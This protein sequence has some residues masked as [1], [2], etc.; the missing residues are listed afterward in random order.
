MIQ[1]NTAKPYRVFAESLEQGAIDQFES[2]MQCPFTVEGALMPD[3]HMGYSLPIGAVVVTKGVIVPAWVGFDIG[4]GVCALPV[5]LSADKVRS[6]AKEIYDLIRLSVPVGFAHNKED[7][8]WDH[9]EEIQA[10]PKLREIFDKNGLKQLG[11]L[12]GG[13][14]FIEVGVDLSEQVWVV[15]HSGS[16]GIGHA[17]ATHHMK[18]ASG[19]GKAREG[20]YGLEHST[21]E[22]GD[23]WIDQGFCLDFARENRRQIVKRVFDVLVKVC[24]EPGSPYD[25]R[26]MINRNHNHVEPMGDWWIHRKGATHAEEGMTGVIPGNMRDGSFIVI[27]KGNHDY[28]W[29]SSHGAGRAMGGKEAQRKLSMDSF[30]EEMKGVTATVTEDTLDES[31]Q[32]Y[33]DVHDVMAQQKDTVTVLNHIRPV[34]NVKG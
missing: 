18:V 16:R 20:H 14:H 13:N 29:S 26:L 21:Q 22:A 33:K 11:S 30:K 6:K 34:I 19:E 9:H 10:T 31:P 24:E 17:V 23:Y 4:C 2:A 25:E 28:L 12:G 1:I 5:F 3:A 8:K 15:V 32:A 7:S 27:S